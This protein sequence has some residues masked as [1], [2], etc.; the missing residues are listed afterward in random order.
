VDMRRIALPTEMEAVYLS[1]PDLRDLEHKAPPPPDWQG[2]VDPELRD[3]DRKEHTPQEWQQLMEKT[4]YRIYRLGLFDRSSHTSKELFRLE[5]VGLTLRNYPAAK[6]FLIARGHSASE[7]EA[8]PAP[9]VVMLYTMAHYDEL[10]DEMFKWLNLPYAEARPGLEGAEKQ[11]KE[12]RA[13]QSEIIPLAAML[14][15]A[16]QAASNAQVRHER[17]FALLRVLEALRLYGAAH[18]RLPDKLSDIT[19]VPIPVDPVTGSPF[20]YGRSGDA[21]WLDAPPGRGLS[22]SDW[23]LRRLDITF[24]P[25]GK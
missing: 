11:L 12:A 13:R 18:N 23:V 2:L 1:F 8:M 3:L 25:K 20:G 19:E 24:V 15:P 21:A 16:L 5:V 14:L 6:R 10:R 9:K 7:V 4:I 22:R 17:T